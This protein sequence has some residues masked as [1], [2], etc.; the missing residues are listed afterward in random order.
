[1]GEVHLDNEEERVELEKLPRKGGVQKTEAEK[2]IK[3]KDEEIIRKYDVFNYINNHKILSQEIYHWLLN[4]QNNSNSI[5]LLGYFNYHGIGTDLN[6][7]KA[8]Q[9]YQKQQS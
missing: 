4:N 5:Y 7:Q 9:L 1:M 2:E 6:K 8:I 3:E